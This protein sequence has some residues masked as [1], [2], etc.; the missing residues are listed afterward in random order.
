MFKQLKKLHKDSQGFTLV[1]LMIVVA[2]IGILAAIAI[3]Q[4]AA[5]QTRARNTTAAA[6][7]HQG[8]NSMET[9][10]SDI[11]VYGIPV[12]GVDLQ[13]A[14]GDILGGLVDIRAVVGNMAPL[15][16]AQA[17]VAGLMI[18]GT[19]SADPA[20]LR[21][22]AMGVGLG[23]DVYVVA[24]N[25]AGANHASYLL[26]SQH[27]RGNAAWGLDSDAPNTIY[28]VM[29]DAWTQSTGAIEVTLPAASV[30][31]SNDLNNIPAGGAPSP[32]WGVK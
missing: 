24:G 26:I 5:Y 28:T 4:F 15:A 17:T 13:N 3:P 1:E 9:M 30:P 19:N 22:G 2:I 23:A 25:E 31:G 20:N 18:T 14:P 29:N 21:I 12:D 27:E 11:G 10:Q 16:P 32:N 7:G 8:I 6:D